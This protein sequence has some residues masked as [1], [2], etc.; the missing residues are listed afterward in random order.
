MWRDR[1]K[2]AVVKLPA[3]IGSAEIFR[4]A[5]FMLKNFLWFKSA[6]N[7]D[8]RHPVL[9]AQTKQCGYPHT[10]WG[11]NGWLFDPEQLLHL[12]CLQNGRLSRALLQRVLIVE[13]IRGPHGAPSSW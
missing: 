5:Y 10:W 11:F 1:L 9:E 12:R 13:P 2:K 6:E 4:K 3:S 8:N 7:R